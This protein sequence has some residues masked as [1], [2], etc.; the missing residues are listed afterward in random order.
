MLFVHEIVHVDSEHAHC[1]FVLPLEGECFSGRMGVELCM[2]EALA[3]TTA[4]MM[5]ITTPDS[6]AGGMLGGVH[7]YRVQARPRAGDTL[8]LHVSVR[9][10]LGPVAM[11]EVE[12]RRG[13]D[14][15]CSGTLTVR[16]GVES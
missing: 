15:L 3:Q 2:V 1:R 8:E 12:A 13:A 16:L 9:K 5:A 7:G 4:V 10:R 14:S 6:V 11:F